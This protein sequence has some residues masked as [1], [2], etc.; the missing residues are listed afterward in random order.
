MRILLLCS[1]NM[2]RSPFAAAWLRARLAQAGVE[3]DVTSAGT[4]TE[5]RPAPSELVAVGQR[6]AVDL[7]SHRSARFS[8]GDLTSADLVV[9]MT[10]QHVREAVSLA[11][12]IWPHCFTLREFVRRGWAIGPRR[13]GQG[14]ES[15]LAEVHAGRRTADLLGSSP[16]DDVEDPMG[17][18]ERDYQATADVLAELVDQLTMLLWP[19]ESQALSS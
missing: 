11:P 2:C 9:G 19:V 18:S 13:P 15:W 6:M 10:R 4:L 1:G 14:V 16:D 3:A 8:S 7:S 12:S 5:D 17:G